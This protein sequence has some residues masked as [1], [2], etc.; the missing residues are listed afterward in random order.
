MSYIFL[1]FMLVFIIW[2][3]KKLERN[4]HEKGLKIYGSVFKKYK[5]QSI[6]NKSH[7]IY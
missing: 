3:G 2:M 5:I 7:P 4:K 6:I 1:I